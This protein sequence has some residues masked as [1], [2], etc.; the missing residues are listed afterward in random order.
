VQNPIRITHFGYHV[1]GPAPNP[2]FKGKWDCFDVHKDVVAPAH[3]G[4][5]LPPPNGSWPEDMAQFLRSKRILLLY[6]GWLDL[7]GVRGEVGRL[8]LPALLWLLLRH[9]AKAQT[10]SHLSRRAVLRPPADVRPHPTPSHPTPPHPTSP[11]VEPYYSF[12]M[13]QV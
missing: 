9:T 7:D 5:L 3:D 11:Q 12:D 4:P 2:W 10:G 8:R 6:S 1:N 13:R